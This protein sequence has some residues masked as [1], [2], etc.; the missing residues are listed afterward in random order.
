MWLARRRSADDL[1]LSCDETVLHSMDGD[2]RR[3]YAE[4]LLRTAG[5][6]RGF[7]T[8]LSAS[9]GALRYR[10]RQVMNPCKRTGGLVV[11]AVAFTLLLTTMGNITVG[12]LPERCSTLLLDGAAADTITVED[13]YT[14]TDSG[15]DKI[16]YRVTDET[17]LWNYLSRHEAYRMTLNW[18]CKNHISHCGTVVER[19]SGRLRCTRITFR[20]CTG[21]G[22]RSRDI[23]TAPAFSRNCWTAVFLYWTVVLQNYDNECAGPKPPHRLSGAAAV[24]SNQSTNF[25]HSLR[26]FIDLL[27]EW[28][29]VINAYAHDEG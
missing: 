10:L 23:I 19:S 22:G 26:N 25:S 15:I 7:T 6:Q 2:C 5:D 29:Y 9:A 14:L 12:Y 28:A 11:T 27:R 21:W 20:V 4:L 18:D 1:E 24:F 13:A 8:C 17:A 3:P 16:H